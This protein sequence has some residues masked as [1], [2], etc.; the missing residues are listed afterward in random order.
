MRLGSIARSS[1]IFALLFWAL[2]STAQQPTQA[3]IHVVVDNYFGHEIAD[4]YRYMEQGTPEASAWIAEQRAYTEAVLGA[5]PERNRFR[6]HLRD[7]RVS[8]SR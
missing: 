6:E 7:L 1:G 5:M 3:P 2:W 4:P 8:I